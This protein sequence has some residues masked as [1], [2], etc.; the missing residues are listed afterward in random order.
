MKFR[1]IDNTALKVSELCMGTMTMGWQTDEALS[2]QI[3]DRAFDRGI[4]FV[5]TADVY[6]SWVEGNPGG[7]AER[8]VGTWL[9]TKPRDRIVLATKVRGRMWEGEDGEG[10]GRK[11]ILRACA[12]SLQRLQVDYIDLYQ[13]HAPDPNTPI[14]ETVDTLCEL[15]REGKV[16]YIGVSNFPADLT[17][18]AND[19]AH[20]HYQCKFICTQPKYNLICRKAFEDDLLPYVEETKMGVIPYSPLEGGLLTGKYKAGQP[21]PQ[22]ARHTLNQRASD[23]MTPQ[24]LKVLELLE[25]MARKR[26]ESMTQTAL[27]W[28]LSKP[29]VTSPIIGATSIQQLDDSLTASGKRLSQEEENELDEV[30]NGL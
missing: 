2:H 26:G 15:I 17:R 23:K 25:L 11:H 24:V 21:L 29:F 4:N 20:T 7:V 16:R 1:T 6:S 30:S 18:R 10:L 12:D 27:A 19:Y 28:L 8:M 9:K 3:L 14:E 13:C 5:D 22:N